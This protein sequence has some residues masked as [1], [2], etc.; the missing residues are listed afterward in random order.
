MKMKKLLLGMTVVASVINVHTVFA[1]PLP[2]TLGWIP[3]G[4]AATVYC[5]A[6]R[7]FPG[8]PPT[9]LV[10]VEAVGGLETNFLITNTAALKTL[11]IAQIDVYGMTTGALITTLK[12]GSDIRTPTGQPA[13]KW[14]LAPYETTRLPNQA[15]LPLTQQSKPDLLWNNVVFT[16]KNT[17]DTPMPA[18]LVYSDYVEKATPKLG[19]GVLARIRADCVYR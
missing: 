7:F 18:P 1:E 9:T 14:S 12:P 8:S 15:T 10:K 16:V 4:G 5:S 11:A 13:F 6:S 17:Y 19:G 2:N 3:A